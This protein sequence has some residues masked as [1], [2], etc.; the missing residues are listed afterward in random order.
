LCGSFPAHANR[1]ARSP[2][3][4]E[5]GPRSA[6]SVRSG[7]EHVFVTSEGS[8]YGRFRRALATGNETLVI[9]AAR[10][11]PRISLDDALRVCLVLRDGEPDRFERAAVRWLGRFAL[12]AKGA[13]MDDL[14]AAADALDALPDRPVPAMEQLQTLCLARGIA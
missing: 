13:T 14:R 1:Y 11:L 3:P 2:Q 12:E 6:A 8:P 10:E 9:A 4:L 5:R 7:S